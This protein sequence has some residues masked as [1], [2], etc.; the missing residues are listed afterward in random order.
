MQLIDFISPDFTLNSIAFLVVLTS[1]IRTTESILLRNELNNNGTLSWKILRLN[2]SL[3]RTG[4]LPLLDVLFIPVVFNT[5]LLLSL[6]SGFFF[7]IEDNRTI[8]IL[9]FSFVALINLSLTVRIYI[10][11][12]GADNVLNVI[13]IPT[14]V[15]LLFNEPGIF[16]A[17]IWFISLQLFSLYCFSGFFK[18]RS[19]DWVS[20]AAVSQVLSSGRF[21]NP[22]IGIKLM[23]AGKHFNTLLCWATILYQLLFPLAVLL[24]FNLF[25]CFLAVGLCFH[26]CI[27][28]VMG[29]NRFFFTFLCGYPALLHFK[30]AI[31]PIII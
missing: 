12:D 14:M 28:I 1:M 27:A 24:P 6:I 9:A 23:G 22:A 5:L 16:K 3:K 19:S 15:S 17:G 4:V 11:K 7:F 10:A 18:L 20:G 30:L 13:A 2:S 31:L 29:L 8:H 25:V 26:F 21:G